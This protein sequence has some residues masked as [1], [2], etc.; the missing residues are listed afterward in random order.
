MAWHGACKIGRR[1]SFGFARNFPEKMK[2]FAAI[3]ALALTC[4][5][6][7]ADGTSAT[8]DY[9]PT[10]GWRE[11]TP[12]SQG[13]DSEKLATILT[14]VRDHQTPIHGLVVIRHGYVVFDAV[15][16]PYQHSQMHD[17]ASCTKSVTATLVGAAIEQGRIKS[18]HDS[19]RSYFPGEGDR[20]AAE[21][22]NDFT[23]E[24]LLTMR[25]G[26]ACEA[27]PGEP[28]EMF[29]SPNWAQFVLAQPLRYRPGTHFLY[30]SSAFHLLSATL[31]QAVGKSPLDFARTTLFRPLGIESA[32][33]PE[34]SAGVNH[35]WGDLCLDPL[36]MAKIGFLYLHGGTWDSRRILPEDFVR[37]ATRLEDR[38]DDPSDYGYGWWIYRPPGSAGGPDNRVGEFDA[39]GRGG[40]RIVVVPRLDLIMVMVGSGF[41]PAQIGIPVF[42]AVVSEAP[43]PA[44]PRAADALHS[45]VAQAG[46]IPKDEGAPAEFSAEQEKCS[47]TYALG[48]NPFG[49]SSISFDFHTS[50]GAALELTYR[51][52]SPFAE[53]SRRWH[54]IGFGPIPRYSP[55][56]P[57]GFPVGVHGRWISPTHL[58]LVYDEIASINCYTFDVEIR[59]DQI[60]M[61]VSERTSPSWT[62]VVEGRLVGPHPA[63]AVRTSPSVLDA[64][65]RALGAI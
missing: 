20:T 13:M 23:I 2:T 33:W 47:G 45:L 42:K 48:D 49:L 35:G 40:Q 1:P 46:V 37:A 17:I 18:V 27:T 58:T 52:G 60:H 8:P 51:S 3:V 38:K 62:S 5:T 21:A 43:L 39:A 36:D 57:E 6:G 14:D 59:G 4:L 7:R 32:L 41:D 28:R 50:A 10:H 63:A 65:M 29:A 16:A 24:N 9:W 61:T 53:Q 12:E 34:D 22:D 26:I 64:E 25:S 54:P 30:S 55:G 15:F 31:K 56:G 44:N 19:V 11:S